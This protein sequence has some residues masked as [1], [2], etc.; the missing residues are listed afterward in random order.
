MPKLLKRFANEL[1]LHGRRRDRHRHGARPAP[2]RAQLTLKPVGQLDH[3][4]PRRPTA[5][6]AQHHPRAAVGAVA[7]SACS[8]AAVLAAPL[9]RRSS[10]RRAPP[11]AGRRRALP[12]SQ[13]VAHL[14]LPSGRSARHGS[15]AGSWPELDEQVGRALDERRSGR[16]RSTRG[17]LLGRGPERAQHRRRRRG[18]T[19]PVPARRRRARERDVDAQRRA[20]A[21]RR[22][23]R[24]RAG[25]PRRARR[26]AAARRRRCPAPRGGAA[27]PSAARARSRRPTS[28]SGPPSP[29]RQ[30]KW[31]PIGPRT[32]NSSPARTSPAR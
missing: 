17:A 3:A 28:S 13:A 2:G 5:G 11:R 4:Q 25:P 20:S 18:A 7:P 8:V 12:S 16:T 32:S 30:V 31:P 29:T 14:S 24:G 9:A 23:R 21:A 6:A 1:Q 10:P 22:A 27:S 19:Q 15:R 26:R